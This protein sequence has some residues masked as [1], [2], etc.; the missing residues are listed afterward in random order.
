MKKLLLLISVF[1]ILCASVFADHSLHAGLMYSYFTG[2]DRIKEFNEPD[3]ISTSGFGFCFDYAYERSNGLVFKAGGDISSMKFT[4]D[5]GDLEIDKGIEADIYFGLGYG[6]IKK[7]N[8]SLFFTGNAGVKGDLF[9]E[10]GTNHLERVLVMFTVGPELSF[11]YRFNTHLGL[12]AN[13]GAMFNIGSSNGQAIP[14]W[15]QTDVYG[16]SFPVKA[17]ISYTF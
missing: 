13:A 6:F 12:F 2:K 15:I 14:S 11:N 8:M 3:K 16:F 17:G 10:N 7:G 9:C 5:M 1:I 4:Y